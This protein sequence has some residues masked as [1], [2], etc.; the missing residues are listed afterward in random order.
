M[1]G[2]GH[3]AES[4]SSDGL[5]AALTRGGGAG[6]GLGVLVA[7][8]PPLRL[9]LTID[10]VVGSAEDCG[11]GRPHGEGEGAEA[12]AHLADASLTLAP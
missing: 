5:G 7:G 2:R 3:A 11:C 10:D 9:L 1:A 12:G 6:G 8:A 4:G